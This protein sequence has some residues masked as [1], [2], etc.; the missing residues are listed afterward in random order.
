MKL[1]LALITFPFLFFSINAHALDFYGDDRDPVVQVV[2]SGSGDP[3]SEFDGVN[4]A[5]NQDADEYKYSQQYRHPRV[6]RTN[7]AVGYSRAS[8]NI[9]TREKVIIIDPVEHSWG[10]YSGGKLLRSG[11]AT[12]GSHWCS[13]LGRPC[14]TR[15]GTFRIYSLGDSSCVSSKF[16][17]GEGGAPMPYCMYFNG[18]QALHGSYEVVA[19]NISHGCVRLHVDDARW[20][21]FHFAT[22]GTKVIVRPY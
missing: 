1:V 4:Y 15:S 13:D 10:A 9:S 3:F 14:R 12:A 20:I 16:P 19:G 22:I 6:H 11:L 21:R 5:Y 17:L 7:H 18:A 8:Q 2:G